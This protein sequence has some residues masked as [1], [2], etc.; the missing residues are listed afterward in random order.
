MGCRIFKK[1]R[2]FIVL[3]ILSVFMT[4]CINDYLAECKYDKYSLT[5]KVVNAKGDDITPLGTVEETTLYVFNEEGFFVDSVQMN[6]SAIISRQQ[7][8]LDFPADAKLTVIGWGGLAGGSQTVV[9]LTE[10]TTLKDFQ[11]SLIKN[12]DI[13]QA[14]DRLYHGV[15]E[16]T[17]RAGELTANHEVVIQPKI[18]QASLGTLNFKYYLNRK[19]SSMLKNG[20]RADTPTDSGNLEFLLDRTLSSFDYQGN[21]QGDS[22][23]YI[24]DAELTAQTEYISEISNIMPGEEF[25]LTLFDEGNSIGYRNRDDDGKIF[26]AVPD[27]TLLIL[28]EF[29]EDGT[30]ISAKTAVRPWG[31]LIQEVVF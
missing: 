2:L 30:V 17:T 3:C 7:V 14:P 10:K 18:A 29:G 1:Q 11:V 9:P 24:P 19:N 27:S 21:M 5:V 28:L 8:A 6:K 16:V 13:A 12:N 15:E 22:V 4:G 26:R 23:S 25:G 31:T 20:T